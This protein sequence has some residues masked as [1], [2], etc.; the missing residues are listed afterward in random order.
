MVDI[1]RMKEIARVEGHYSLSAGEGLINDLGD[2]R[3]EV[4]RLNEAL[5]ACNKEVNFQRRARLAHETALEAAHK[6]LV[7]NRADTAKIQNEVETLKGQ[8]AKFQGEV[9]ALKGQAD[10]V[11]MNARKQQL[12]I[13]V[14]AGNGLRKAYFHDAHKPTDCLICTRRMAAWEQALRDVGFAEVGPGN[15]FDEEKNPPKPQDPDVEM[16]QAQIVA[17]RHQLTL[18]AGVALAKIGHLEEALRPAK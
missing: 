5:A 6:E 4:S 13:L 9:E 10:T 17:L 11:L 12:A 15:A 18:I 7:V 2:A 14:E 8:Q 16:L 1:D 3:A